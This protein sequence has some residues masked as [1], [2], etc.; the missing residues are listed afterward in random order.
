[1]AKEKEDIK[2]TKEVSENVVTERTKTGATYVPNVDIN[3]NEDGL[4]LLADMP[5]ATEKDVN[6]TLEN[7][8]LTIDAQVAPVSI[9]AH[10]LSYREY[11]VGD[12][13]RAFTISEAIDRNKIEARIKDGVLRIKLPKA[14]EAKPKTIPIQVG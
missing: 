5:G 13:H 1:M 14:Q 4:V 12:Y 2:G 11:G 7:D 3:E 6:I 10:K 8:V 9:N